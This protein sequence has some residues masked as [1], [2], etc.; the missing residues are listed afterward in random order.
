MIRQHGFTLIE[1]LVVISIIALLIALLLPALN[2]AR[3]A[4]RDVL[5][6]NHIRQ[7]SLAHLVY[8]TDNR[9]TM[10]PGGGMSG[11]FDGDW[12]WAFSDATRS[13]SRSL[14]YITGSSQ[15]PKIYACPDSDLATRKIGRGW[16]NRN[17]GDPEVNF[18]YWPSYINPARTVG[19]R[20]GPAPGWFW[21][22][23]DR[24]PGSRV[25]TIEKLSGLPLT[26]HTFFEEQ[27]TL[28]PYGASAGSPQTRYLDSGLLDFRHA[29]GANANAAFIDGHSASVSREDVAQ[30][31]IDHITNDRWID[32]VGSK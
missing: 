19:Y 28:R 4:A 12:F 8:A 30:A 23:L 7:V 9:G 22:R 2:Q 11:G 6:K 3:A 18:R 5:C 29:S 10:R 24:L 17:S 32:Y 15:F 26:P 31:M 25:L 27:L 14:G 21:Q 16:D 13:G 1:L 20:M